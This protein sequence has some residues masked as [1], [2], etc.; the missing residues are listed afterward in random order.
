MRRKCSSTP[1]A[2]STP[3]SELIS[4]HSLSSELSF[5]T[6][7]VA[8]LSPRTTILTI[9]ITPQI[10]ISYNYKTY[11]DWLILYIFKKMVLEQ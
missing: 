1:A 11:M 6:R 7:A 10:C 9:T 4:T 3:A 8:A 2:T 5:H